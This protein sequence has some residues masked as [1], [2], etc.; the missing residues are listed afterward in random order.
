M[1][2][3]H[4]FCSHTFERVPQMGKCLQVPEAL[5]PLLL[6][7]RQW[8]DN[9]QMHS[10]VCPPPPPPFCSLPYT[11]GPSEASPPSQ[12]SLRSLPQTRSSPPHKHAAFSAMS[13]WRGTFPWGLMTLIQIQF[14]P[15]QDPACVTLTGYWS[16]QHLTSL[17]TKW[18]QQYLPHSWLNKDRCS[19][20]PWGQ[21][22][23]FS[24]TPPPMTIKAASLLLYLFIFSYSCLRTY[25]IS[26]TEL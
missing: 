8:A 19:D 15:L 16:S 23:A 4:K 11:G 24:R 14:L 2:T 17:L 3:F 12:L 6:T 20:L 5:I 21:G 13:E 9:P 25:N 22:L 18:K 10:A 1:T 7:C 26:L